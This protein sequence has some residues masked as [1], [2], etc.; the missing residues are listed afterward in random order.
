MS[1]FWRIHLTV[2]VGSAVATSILTGA[3]LVGDSVRGSLRDLSQD[4]LGRIDFALLSERFFRESL[5]RDLSEPDTFADRFASATPAILL[6]GSVRNAGTQARASRVQ[7]QGIDE[8]FTKLFDEQPRSGDRGSFLARPKGQTFPSVAINEALREEL[9]VDVGDAIVLSLER[10]TKINREFLFGIDDP[11]DITQNLR[12]VVSKVIP[13]KGMGRFGLDLHQVLRLNAFVSLPVLQK[14]ISQT[15]LVNTI[16]VSGH[17][18]ESESRALQDLLKK[19]L[20]LGD[21]GLRVRAEESFVSIESSSFLLKPGT[22][23]LVEE[24]ASENSIQAL[25]VLT[26]LANSLRVGERETPYSTISAMDTGVLR[27]GG[28]FGAFRTGND[29]SG[30]RLNEDGIV[31]NDWA[32][33][34]LKASVGDTVTVSYYLVGPREELLTRDA[35]F[36][37]EKVVSMDGLAVDPTLTPDFPGIEE[38]DRM[39][40]WDAPFPVDLKRIREEDEVY[41]EKYRSAPKAFVSLQTGQRLWESRFG[42]LSGIRLAT[43]DGSETQALARKLEKDLPGLLSPESVGLVF[44]AVKQEGIEASSGATDF[45]MLFIGFSQ[46]LIVSAALL[47]GL[48]FRLGVEQRAGEA[49]ILLA[50]GYSLAE[51]RRRFLVEGSSLAAVGGVIGIFGAVLYG[52]LMM[53][54]LRTLWASA[55][56]TS[57]LS[58]HTNMATLLIG[59]CVSV[60]VVIFTVWRTVRQLGKVPV[61][62]LLPGMFALVSYRSGKALRLIGPGSLVLAGCLVLAADS[63]GSVGMFFGSGA[64]LLVAGLSFTSIWF[65]RE[66]GDSVSSRRSIVG[67]GVRNSSRLPGRSLL[68]TSLIACACFVIV[69]VGA[70]RRTEKVGLEQYSQSGSGGFALLA[71]SDVPIHSDLNMEENKLGLGF[72]D[73]EMRALEATAFYPFRVLP[74]DDVSCLNLYRPD[75]PRVLGVPDDIIQ[76]GGFQFQQILR[77]TDRPWTLLNENLGPDMV[78]AFGDFNS[79]MWILQKSMGDDVEIRTENGEVVKLRLVGLFSTS[80]FQGELLISEANFLAH[81][82]GRSGYGFHL[83]NTPSDTAPQVS[84]LLERRLGEWGFDVTSTSGRLAEYRAVENTYLS[85]FQTLGGLGLILGTIGLGVVLF[86]N[87]L[88]RRRELAVMQ[89]FGFRKGS[90]SI[91]LLAENTFLLTLGIL[92]GTVS[93][94]LAVSPHLLAPGGSIPWASLALTLFLVFLTGLTTTALATHMVLK[95]PLLPA[96]KED[97]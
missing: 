60:V 42:S 13:N 7:I 73:E 43:E 77:K 25:R 69:A 27:D 33:R 5:A 34:D 26:Y 79:V 1:Y 85:T 53:V 17:E 95:S 65:K 96:L 94:L 50:S 68:C 16:L 62:S 48:L 83:I 45:S 54:G 37:L 93:A 41:W 47:V 87:A 57:H 29:S 2:V 78:P 58:L 3:L 86:R 81:F 28:P 92:I 40:S 88:E 90:L 11:E 22:A 89:S 71:E 31:L 67:L 21:I 56:G 76:R 52:W 82:P 19:S 9:D 24:W 38:A 20:E 91:M 23:R 6:S 10:P 74:G 15:G 44:R 64:L 35:K 70:N 55:V 61:Q 32:A 30:S 14:A 12:L 80:I 97:R 39:S 18:V 51:V 84:G 46:F 75:T 36:R 66:W 59:Y 63:T 8:R 72:S 4:R 49:G